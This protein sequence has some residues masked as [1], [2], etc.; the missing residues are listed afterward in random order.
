[1]S[2]TIPGQESGVTNA[3]DPYFGPANREHYDNGN[4]TMTAIR[5]NTKEILPDPEPEDRRREINTPAFLKPSA[6]RNRLSAL[7]KILQTIP[8]SREALLNRE[9]TI[10][11]Y[12]HDS[13]WW[14]GSAI[15]APKTI[16]VAQEG[17]YP[18]D[19]ELI[20][21]TQRLIAFLEETERAYGSVESLLNVEGINRPGNDQLLARYLERW[22]AITAKATPNYALLNVFQSTGIKNQGTEP[23]LEEKHDFQVLE[24]RIDEVLADRG[25]TLYDAI[26]D[27]LWADENESSFE[28]IYISHLGEIFIVDATCVSET[29]SGLGIRIPPVWYSDRYLK[30]SIPQTKEMKAG[31]AEVKKEI[32]RIHHAEEQI[33]KLQSSASVTTAIDPTELLN[34]TMAFFQRSALLTDSSKNVTDDVEQNSLMSQGPNRYSRTAD[35]LKSLTAMIQTKIESIHDSV[36]TWRVLCSS[37]SRVRRI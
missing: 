5:S 11:D 28:N 4:W 18:Q 24:L 35:R 8:M 33:R 17:Q 12:G 29:A 16:N 7:I 6:D 27:I 13:E 25:H 23:W 22:R 26:D 10:R 19:E 1:M 15:K 14:D 34:T 21:E 30:S 36:Q 3:S 32:Q 9:N 37:P 2:Q 20:H 31:K